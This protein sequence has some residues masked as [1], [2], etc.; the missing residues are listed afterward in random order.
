MYL[1]VHTPSTRVL[2]GIH[3]HTEPVVNETQTSSALHVLPPHC[4][5]EEKKIILM[6]IYWYYYRKMNT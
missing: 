5:E 3:S 1:P 6:S 4:P 2:P